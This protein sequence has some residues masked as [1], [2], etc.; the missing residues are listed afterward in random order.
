MPEGPEIRIAA[1]TIANVLVGNTVETIRFGLPRLR[2]FSKQL[3]GHRVIDV[4]TRGKALL[5]HF[6]HGYSIYS[7]NQLYGVWKVCSGHKLPKSNR[8]MRI[9]LQTETHSAVLYSASDISVWPTEELAEH[10]F[11]R[12]L[13][14][15]IMNPALEWREIAA[16]LQDPRFER[17]ELAAL[18]LDQSFLAGN[19]NYLRSEVTHHAGLHPKQKPCELTRAQLG[20]LARSTLEISRRSY[21]TRGIT[22]TPRLSKTLEKR[23]VAR[24]SRRFYVFGR[25]DLPCYSCSTPIKY[26]E[27]NS[28]RLY[29]CPQCQ[30]A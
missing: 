4:E 5:T 8:S 24:G 1:D 7:H 12:K 14:P 30:P 25:D 13:G 18:Y 11:L 3:K 6:D 21:D 22:I 27:I 29:H 16:R 19:G 10:P 15:D 17:R 2:H 23:G 20:K 26:S 28:R 9:L